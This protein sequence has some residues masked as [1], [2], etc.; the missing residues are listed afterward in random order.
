MLPFFRILKTLL[1]RSVQSFIFEDYEGNLKT[2]NSKISFKKEEMF[3]KIVVIK[4]KKNS[5]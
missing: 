1:R 3:Q 2:C 4:A 5:V